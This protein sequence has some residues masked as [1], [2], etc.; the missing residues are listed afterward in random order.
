MRSGSIS[1]SVWT[2]W[3]KISCVQTLGEASTRIGSAAAQ[4]SRI[5][6]QNVPNLCG[7]IRHQTAIRL[8]TPSS[9]T[10]QHVSPCARLGGGH[11]S[12][13]HAGLQDGVVRDGVVRHLAVKQRICKTRLRK[14]THNPLHRDF[15]M[16]SIGAYR[17]YRNCI[18]QQQQQ[19]QQH[20]DESSSSS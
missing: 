2:I 6:S 12:T 5:W 20:H 8:P 16:I 19:Q 11:I 18:K 4:V 9:H 15:L 13:F 3:S 17:C 7:F 1:Y 14:P 10:I